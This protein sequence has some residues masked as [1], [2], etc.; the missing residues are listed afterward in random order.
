MNQ[1]DS[2]DEPRIKRVE[3]GI[4]EHTFKDG[5]IADIAQQIARHW[6]REH[7]DELGVDQKPFKTEEY[8]GRHLHGDEYAYKVQE[9]YVTSYDV[10]NVDGEKP[11]K[12]QYVKK[13]ES[14]DVCEDCWRSI[15]GVDGY[16]EIDDSGW[17]TK[18]R[19]DDCQRKRDIER[20]KTENESL[21]R[22]A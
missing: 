19:C 4:C 15:R 5:T 8:A 12:Y 9:Y 11:F 10:L 13:P 20:R 1:T 22:F 2:D 7:G 17:R 3:C 6:N 21:G 14:V 16:R 18:Y